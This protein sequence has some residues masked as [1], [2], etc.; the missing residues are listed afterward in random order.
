MYEKN[1]WI[2]LKSFSRSFIESRTLKTV[3]WKSFFK[4][5]QPKIIYQ[6]LKV[7]L[8]KIT[9][10]QSHIKNHHKSHFSKIIIICYPSIKS[11]L[12]QYYHWLYHIKNHYKSHLTQHYHHNSSINWESAYPRSSSTITHGKSLQELLYPRSLL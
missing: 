7:A 2:W 5:Y 6:S 1:R 10:R 8:P 3:N 4:N 11:H 12:T 9:Y